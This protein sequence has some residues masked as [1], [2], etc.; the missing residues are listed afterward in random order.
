MSRVGLFLI[1][2]AMPLIMV[3]QFQL[4]WN[5]ELD[6]EL[7]K[8]GSSSHYYYNEIHRDYADWKLDIARINWLTT[9]DWSKQWTLNAHLM[10]ER[11]NGRRA[12]LFHDLNDY[13]VHFPILN[14][15]KS[16]PG[17]SLS[18]T[19]GR[20]I[21]PFGTFYPQQLNKDRVFIAAPLAYS[22]FTNVSQYVGLVEGLGEPASLKIEGAPDWGTP[23]LYRLG[24]QSG[25]R[26]DWGKAEK[27]SGT[28]AVVDGASNQLKQSFRPTNLG[29]VS[30][31]QFQVAYFS[32]FG[33]SFSH[34][35][36]L[37]PASQNDSLEHL[38][39][40]RQTLVG[41]NYSFG[42]GFFELSGELIA[43]YYKAPQFVAMENRFRETEQQLRVQNLSA[44]SGYID[45][46]YEFSFIPGSYIAYRFD[47]LRFG[48]FENV[49]NE[50]VEWDNQ[51]I[52]HSLAAGYKINSFTQLKTT[53]AT[54]QVANRD[55]DNKQRVLRLMLIFHW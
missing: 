5:A 22:H 48:N 15:K 53:I 8:A 14:I 44:F 4:K 40:Y 25:I 45:L 27:L 30:S 37:H 6:T 26:F 19:V 20:F 2:L 47:L 29:I 11:K 36:F 33:V 31:A 49:N 55:W 35:S 12:G 1:C 32:K 13:V 41:V 3:G 38:L 54:Q 46:K 39:K 16:F 21:N 17:D 10:V 18:L 23:L 50:N 24:Y 43:A 42:S 51:V 52:R 28:I 34:G 7:T 9:V